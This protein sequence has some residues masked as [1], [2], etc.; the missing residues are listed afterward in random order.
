MCC[1]KYMMTSVSTQE[2]EYVFII[3]RRF[4]GCDYSGCDRGGFF[5]RI[6]GGGI[7][8]YRGRRITGDGLLI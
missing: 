3:G 1:D 6:C 7:A 2:V 4:G 8:G 5:R